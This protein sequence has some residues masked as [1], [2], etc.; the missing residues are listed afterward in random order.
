METK[1]VNSNKH[2]SNKMD[3]INR[4]AKDL[5]A[6]FSLEGITLTIDEA[7][8]MVKESYSRLEKEK[9]ISQS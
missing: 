1:V 4:L 3:K 2:L 7:I 8:E 6:S 5:V 9:L